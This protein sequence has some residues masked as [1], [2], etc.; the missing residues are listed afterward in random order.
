MPEAGRM[1]DLGR[2]PADGH[3]C[4]R[5]PHDVQGP[6]TAGSADV[7]VNGRQALRV[8]DPGDHAGCCGPNRWQATDG[9]PAVFI[10]GRRAHRRGDAQAHCGGDGALVT[11][12]ADVLIGDLSGGAATEPPHDQTVA[13]TYLDATGREIAGCVVHVV[14]PHRRY[15][16]VTFDGRTTITGLCKDAAVLV[17]NQLEHHGADE[18]EDDGEPEVDD[19]GDDFG[20]DPAWLAEDPAEGGLS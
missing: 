14:C 5:C 8:G 1:G 9:A 10:N 19:D 4:P 11:G 6:A 12:S 7:L 18:G 16:D 13:L 3:G 15:P 20:P 2:C 17:L